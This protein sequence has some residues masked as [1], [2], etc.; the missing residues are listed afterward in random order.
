MKMF[1][2][3]WGRDESPMVPDPG[4]RAGAQEFPSPIVPSFFLCPHTHST[5]PIAELRCPRKLWSLSYESASS[6]SQCQ[7]FK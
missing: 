4:C 3:C 6:S 7:N 2:S 1:L 5:V